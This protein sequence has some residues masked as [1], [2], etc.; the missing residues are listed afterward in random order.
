M[1]LIR[2]AAAAALLALAACST[3]TGGISS[4]GVLKA[5][6]VALT[7][8]ADVYQPAVLA[9]GH[10]PTCPA[11]AICKDNAV[12]AK[13]KAADLAVT[14]TLVAARP[15]LNGTLPDKGQLTDALV[16]IQQA[17]ATIAGSGALKL[18]Q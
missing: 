8:Y 11:A 13:L 12:L 6:Q 10:L 3:P 15:I 2:L 14:N 1:K 4:P 18:S 16:A 5:T 7:T 17:E 9:Y